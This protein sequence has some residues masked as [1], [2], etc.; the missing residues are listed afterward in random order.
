MNY[1]VDP[2]STMIGWGR[3]SLFGSKAALFARVG[4]IPVQAEEVESWG[5]FTTRDGCY[6]PHTGEMTLDEGLATRPNLAWIS[7]ANVCP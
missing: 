2:H 3:F 5:T 4:R 1:P 6:S 7:I